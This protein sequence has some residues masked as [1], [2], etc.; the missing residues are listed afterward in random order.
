MR[1]LSFQEALARTEDQKRHLLLGNGFSISLFP[2]RFRYGSL[3][4]EADFTDLTELRTAFN[5]LKTTDFELVIHALRQA[6]TLLPLYSDDT[7][8]LARM[9][10][11]AEILKERLVQAIAGKHPSRP[12]EITPLQYQ[13]C[14]KFLCHFAGESRKVCRRPGELFSLNYD[15][16]LYWVS[17]HGEVELPDEDGLLHTVEL[18]SID[19]DDGFR[20]PDGDARTDYVAWDA[21]EAYQQNIYYLHG[22]L[23]LYDYGYELQKICWHRSGG[24]P[25]V[26]QIRASLGKNRFPLFVSEGKSD[27]KLNRILHSGYLH[28]GLRKFHGACCSKGTLFI[29]G[30]SLADND[31]HILKQISTGKIE[32]IFVS[33]YGNPDSVEN[34]TVVQRAQQI[35]TERD[36]RF[37]LDV[38]FYAAESVDI[39]GHSS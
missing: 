10:E 9:G 1:I 7:R 14:R 2:D 30:H 21:E 16:L 5:S 24:K 25:L 8:L 11:H 4:E 29:F 13:S 26:D 33:L 19:H 20:N 37:P 17:L 36:D 38:L 6:V 23:H 27:D 32:T 3:L 28:N 18:E 39:W 35:A 15:L 34:K 31:A 22:A 12:S